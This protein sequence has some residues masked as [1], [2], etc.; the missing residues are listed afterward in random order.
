[1]TVKSAFIEGGKKKKDYLLSVSCWE[2]SG[3]F[4]NY[5]IIVYVFNV[6]GYGWIFQ[7]LLWVNSKY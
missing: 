5:R 4:N 6:N 1:M 7:T 3:K 2:K